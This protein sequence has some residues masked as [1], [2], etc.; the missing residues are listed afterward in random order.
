MLPAAELG[1]PK[2]HVPTDRHGS[3][4]PAALDLEAQVDPPVHRPLFDWTSAMPDAPIHSA[5]SR[6]SAQFPA[7][8]FVCGSARCPTRIVSWMKVRLLLA[9]PVA[10]LGVYVVAASLNR[11]CTLNCSS[12][13]ASLP[14]ESG[15]LHHSLTVARSA[16]RFAVLTTPQKNSSVPWNLESRAQSQGS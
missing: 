6:R 10:R 8:R 9:L 12:P 5:P 2:A 3:D 4:F 1:P 16:A 13:L 14:T 15:A 7:Q 11:V